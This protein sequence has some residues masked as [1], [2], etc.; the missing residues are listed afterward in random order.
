MN[1]NTATT[2]KNYAEDIVKA[3]S[4]HV[5]FKGE[6]IN[7]ELKE[8]SDGY[9]LIILIGNPTERFFRGLSET[10][11][12]VGKDNPLVG[13]TTLKKKSKKPR[14]DSVEARTLQRILSESLTVDRYSFQE[15]FFER[16]IR[17]VLGVE[18]QIIA[19]A[20]HIVFGRRGAGKSSL[21]LYA[22]HTLEKEKRPSAWISMQTY[23]E[24]SDLGVI[25]NLLRELLDQTKDVASDN[26]LLRLVTSIVHRL[27]QDE[28]RIRDSDLKKLSPNLRRLFASIT[29]KHG[30]L[31]VFLD[32]LHVVDPKLQPQLLSFLYSFSRG[33]RV[34]LKVSGIENISRIWDPNRRLGLEA[35]N[36]A[37]VIRLDYNLTMPD[38]AREH[39]QNILNAHAEYSGLPGIL[40]LCRNESLSRLVWVAAGVPRDAL[41]IFSNALSKSAH[42]REK[43]VS[44]TS[45]N[46][47]ASEAADFK[48]QSVGPDSSG[49]YEHELGPI[50]EKISEFCIE[51]VRKNA[52]LVRIVSENK[53]YRSILKLID[54]RFLHVLSPQITPDR[55]G[56]R[57]MALLLD[58]GFY[59]GMR[60]AKR[61]DLFQ[62]GAQSLQYNVLRKLP[63][64]KLESVD[65]KRV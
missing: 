31:T 58:Y 52:F 5:G 16:Y 45:I 62:K 42:R 47:A 22:M 39:I 1:E 27:L 56:V 6:D 15:D 20:N 57:Y 29:E 50:L 3:F 55:A 17:S 53:E 30:N 33:N 32:D 36:D 18:D 44:V 24:R 51:V 19:D 54:L 11:D 26:N 8:R 46:I 10:I 65:P 43:L 61:I 64:Y 4:S 25:A 37:Q 12:S 21:L 40:S 41:N 60:T 59:T 23:H 35:P 48:L 7:Y 9:F 13:R 14:I 28:D 2:I 63:K 34:Y 38:R 49:A